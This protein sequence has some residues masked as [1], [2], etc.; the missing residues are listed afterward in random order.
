M[1]TPNQLFEQQHESNAVS[2]TSTIAQIAQP[3][4]NP[5]MTTP[6][7]PVSTKEQEIDAVVNEVTSVAA[8]FIPGGAVA[9]KVAQ[10]TGLAP[11]VVHLGF[12]FAHLFSHPKVAPVVAAAAPAPSDAPAEPTAEQIAAAKKADAIA[13]IQKQM[14]DLQAQLNA[15][16]NG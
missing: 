8:P 11:A 14:L 4:G 6:V 7:A 16:Q 10:M 12:M 2:R 5:T 3:K 1:N 9:Q 15:L 13:L